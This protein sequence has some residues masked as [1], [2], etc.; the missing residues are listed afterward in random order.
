MLAYCHEGGGVA[1]IPRG[2][3]RTD[4][5]KEDKRIKDNF[6]SLSRKLKVKDIRV[7][8]QLCKDNMLKDHFKKQLSHSECRLLNL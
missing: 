8:Q 7:F 6:R 2:K 1:V 4:K 5:A 3:P